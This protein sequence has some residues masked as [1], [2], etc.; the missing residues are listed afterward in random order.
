MAHVLEPLGHKHIKHS[1][2][3]QSFLCTQRDFVFFS[4]FICIDMWMQMCKYSQIKQTM[5]YP[6]ADS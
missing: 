5:L 3:D 1:S 4:A 6:L 2:P